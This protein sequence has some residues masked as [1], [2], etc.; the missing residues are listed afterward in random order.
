MSPAVI[1]VIIGAMASKEGKQLLSILGKDPGVDNMI[2]KGMGM[3]NPTPQDVSDAKALFDS[4]NKAGDTAAQESI[5]KLRDVMMMDPKVRAVITG[6]RA[7][8]E[9]ARAAGNIGVTHAN[10]LAE[11]LLSATRQGGDQQRSTYGL[12]RLEKGAEA[13]GKNKLRQAEIGKHIADAAANVIDKTVGDY[14][15]QDMAVRS[16]SAMPYMQGTPGTL[17]QMINGMQSRA[18]RTTPRE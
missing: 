13:Y 11:A 12:S 10:R 18:Q 2:L 8:S 9:G 5:K 3:K 1:K 17:Y 6:V 7:L 14:S 15:A 16:M 4:Y